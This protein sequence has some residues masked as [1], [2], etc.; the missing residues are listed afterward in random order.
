M[1]KLNNV[2][3][4]NKTVGKEVSFYYEAILDN[5]I[6]YIKVSL[7]FLTDLDYNRII[8]LDKAIRASTSIYLKSIT[9]TKYF[10]EVK[11]CSD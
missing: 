10:N 7:D 8:N 9:S 5:K 3:I 6:K 4:V 11:Q 1:E 2:S